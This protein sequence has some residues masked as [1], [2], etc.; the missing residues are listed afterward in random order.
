MYA[1]EL[2]C[3][4]LNYI[5][6]HL[7]EVISMDM[8]SK[9]FFYDKS[10]LM[11]KFKKAMGVTINYYVNAMRIYS[12]LDEYRTGNSI[13]KIALFHGYHSIEYYSEIFHN[14]IGVSPREYKKFIHYR[15]Y[16][17]EKAYIKMTTSVVKLRMLK[18]SAVE[19]QNRRRPTKQPVK[20]ISL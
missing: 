8:L 17:T 5:H 20:K 3:N 19:Y 2:V 1:D 15:Y 18:Q 14:I 6:D 16:E 10:Y 9:K 11:R 13:L 12:S 4:I 7:Y